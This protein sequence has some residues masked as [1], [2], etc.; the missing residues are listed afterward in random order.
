MGI[1]EFRD[2]R[3]RPLRHLSHCRIEIMDRFTR[4]DHPPE[5]GAPSCRLDAGHG[6]AGDPARPSEPLLVIVGQGYR[7][8]SRYVAGTEMKLDIYTKMVLTVIAVSLSVISLQ[9]LGGVR[10]EA[11]QRPTIQKVLIC[12]P[13]R[14][15]YC[16]EVSGGY[17]QVTNT[18][19]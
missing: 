10:A 14:P 11:Q 3:V 19:N 9:D 18:P 17:L 16:A 6:G 5:K 7:L 2:R 8:F 4:A 1:G 12:S 13:G 15:D